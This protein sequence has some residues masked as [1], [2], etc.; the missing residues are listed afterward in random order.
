MLRWTFLAC[1][2]LALAGCGAG[3]KGKTNVSMPASESEQSSPTYQWK[4]PLDDS[5][6]PSLPPSKPEERKSF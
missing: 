1:V 6:R 2:I 5:P 3:K 4:R